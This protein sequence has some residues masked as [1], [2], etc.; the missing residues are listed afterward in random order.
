MNANT[1]RSTA[2][3]GTLVILVAGALTGCATTGGATSGLAVSH[4]LATQAMPG[5]NLVCTGGHASRLPQQEEQGRV[6][7][8]WPSL[9]L[10]AIY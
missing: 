8:Q 10:D 3:L 1:H 9:S 5:G 2:V 4:A 7:K 6:C